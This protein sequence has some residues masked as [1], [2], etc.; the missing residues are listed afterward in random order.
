MIIRRK[1]KFAGVTL[2]EMMIVLVIFV[3]IGE[4]IAYILSSGEGAWYMSDAKIVA[5]QEGR[6]AMSAVIREVRQ[7]A[8]DV[9]ANCPADGI[10]RAAQLNFNIPA[11]TDGDGDVLDAVENIEWSVVSYSTTAQSQ[12]QRQSGGANSIL[13]NNLLN[14]YFRRQAATPD[15]LEVALWTQKWTAYKAAQGWTASEVFTC[16][17]KMRN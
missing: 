10:W 6:R 16:N 15:V 5:T 8:S 3:L 12:I 4:S 9:I 14:V 2:I 17:I 13:C 11:D 7:S 1:K